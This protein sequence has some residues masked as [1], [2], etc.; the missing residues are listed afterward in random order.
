MLSG[1][2]QRANELNAR[3]WKIYGDLNTELVEKL[4]QGQLHWR[5]ELMVSSCLIFFLRPDA[6]PSEHVTR[7]VLVSLCCTYFVLLHIYAAAELAI[8]S[9]FFFLLQL[10]FARVSVR[11]CPNA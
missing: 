9:L 11:A 6:P 10:V 3:S 2:P 1:I 8:F 7:Y 4:T 5:Y